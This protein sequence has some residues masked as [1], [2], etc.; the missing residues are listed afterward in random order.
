MSASEVILTAHCEDRAGLVASISNWI[1]QHGGNVLHLDQHVD[2]VTSRFFIRVHWSL[3]DFDIQLSEIGDRF[4]AEI[5]RTLDLDY[6]LTFTTVVPRMA[7]FVTKLSHCIWDLL[8]RQESGELNVE[9]PLIISNHE[10]FRGLA[11]RFEIPYHVFEIT[12]ENKAEQEARELALLAAHNVDFIVLARYMQILSDSFVRHYP[13]RIINIH[14]SFL[15]AF[16]GARPYHRAHD[17][18][19]KLIGAT[20]HYVTADLDE[21]PIIEQDTLR[22]SHRDTIADL[23]RTGRDLEKLVLS[24]AVRLHVNKQIVVHGGR[25]LVFD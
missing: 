6:S 19:V 4:S 20:A 3:D 7:V 21:G 23:V 12:K 13:N 11:E 25:T 22:V 15:P 1:Y 10:T 2:A 8:S 14:H 16:A 5:A 18:G 24:R 9:I 17:R